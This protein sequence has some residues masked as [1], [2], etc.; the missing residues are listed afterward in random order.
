MS[1][2]CFVYIRS[3]PPC[4]GNYTGT[5][6]D[7]F[8]KKSRATGNLSVQCLNYMYIRWDK[9]AVYTMST[10]VPSGHYVH[11]SVHSQPTQM[12]PLASATCA[13]HKIK[14]LYTSVHEI[15][16]SMKPTTSFSGTVYAFYGDI[17][18]TR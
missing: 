8:R 12:A 14:T 15:L 11:G 9:S 3:C 10:G 2:S 18:P 1:V 7:D 5:L 13:W 16:H 17:V 6:Y 4:M